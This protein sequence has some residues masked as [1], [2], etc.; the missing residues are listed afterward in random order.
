M[1]KKVLLFICI[2]SLT[3]MFPVRYSQAYSV[4]QT[5]RIGLYFGDKAVSSIS[6]RSAGG[7]TAASKINGSAIG[8]MTNYDTSALLVRKD[9]WFIKSGSTLTLTTQASA[10]AYAGTKFGPYH[11]QIGGAYA[12]YASVNSALASL[13]GVG[14]E[15]YPAYDGAWYA[16]YGCYTDSDT[17]Q[18]EA[19]VLGSR[20]GL[21]CALIQPSN[22]NIVIEKSDGKVFLIFRQT[23]GALQ[24]VPAGGA[25]PRTIYVNGSVYRGAVEIKRNSSSDMTIINELGLEEYLYGVVPKEIEPYSHPEALKAQAIAA[26]TYTIKNLTKHSS[27]GFQLCTTTDCQV[28]GGYSCESAASNSAVDMT[29][30]MI[31]TYN[32]SPAS[33]FYFSSSGGYT[34][35]VRNVWGNLSYPYLISV[36]DKYEKGDSY[37]Y[38]WSKTMTIETLTETMANK[39][40]NVGTVQSLSITKLTS[41]G[42]VLELTVKGSNGSQT[43]QKESCRTAF[44]L[45]SQLYNITLSSNMIV[46]NEEFDIKAVTASPLM[47]INSEGTSALTTSASQLK[48]MGADGIVREMAGA[49]TSYTFVGK[50]WGHSVGMSQEGAKGLANIGYTYE[51]ILNHY[52]PGTRVE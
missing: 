28:Y 37:N 22:D 18:A 15:A 3:V 26:R 52:F 8:L 41:A 1:L 9:S 4:P 47:V 16:W 23:N 42:R 13:S 46:M 51:Q 5:V 25:D 50:G 29:R 27:Y 7:L 30:G 10:A 21:P 2:I 17:A 35:D 20:S 39:G 32:G 31:V 11:I 45:P 33:I 48:I 24:L 19:A 6:V 14:I 49:P 40:Y 38:N 43:F 44:G 34:E 12:D 36:E